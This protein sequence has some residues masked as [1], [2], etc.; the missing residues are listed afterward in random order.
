VPEIEATDIK[1]ML[2][3]IVEFM[4][5]WGLKI[6][7]VLVVLFIAWILAGWARRAL[8]RSLEKSKFD[9]TLTRFF[10][11]TLKYAIIGGTALG[12]L[13]VFGI[14]TTSFA[15]VIGAAGLAVGLAF[16]GT[17]S[18]FAS[19]VM[20]LVFRPFKVGDVVNTAGYI[21]VV[22]ELEL[23]TTEITTPDNRMV[24]IPNSAIFG[25]VIENLTGNDTRRVDVSVGVAYSV[26]VDATREVLEKMIH[27][28][29]GVISDPAPQVFLSGLGASSVDWQ[30]RVW[31]KTGDYWDVHQ[32]TVR[33][34]KK[35][36][37]EAGQPIPFPQMD[38]H[39]DKASLSALPRS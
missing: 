37:D 35:A 12:C 27:D 19:G 3:G 33:Q 30:V 4:T 15:V 16:Q 1:E 13:G 2:G 34:A 7:G 17:L 22:K 21:G 36:L 24:I 20:L 8:T 9:V 31:C 23:F 18:N 25:A 29:P 28:I 26:E 14:E 11:N 38:V 39:L 5:T 6:V 32:A 10:A